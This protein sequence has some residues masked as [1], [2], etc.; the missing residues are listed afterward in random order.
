MKLGI[1]LPQQQLTKS[2]LRYA[3]QLGVTHVIVHGPQFGEHGCHEVEPMRA[4]KNLIE[5]FDLTWEGIENLPHDHW[6]Q[7]LRRRRSRRADG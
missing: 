5:S 7:I 4:T 1:G 2:N 3:A 6:E